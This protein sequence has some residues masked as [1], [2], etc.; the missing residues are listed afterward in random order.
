MGLEILK[1]LLSDAEV[2]QDRLAPVVRIRYAFVFEVY[3]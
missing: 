1:S 2:A 3:W